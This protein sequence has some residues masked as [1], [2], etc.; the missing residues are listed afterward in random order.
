MKNKKMIVDTK[1][2]LL[3]YMEIVESLV[4]NAMEMGDYKAYATTLFSMALFYNYCV[5]DSRFDLEHDIDDIL[6]V[7]ILADDEKFIEEYTKAIRGDGMVRLDFANAVKDAEK[8]IELKMNSV[9]S[10]IDSIKNGVEEIG[11]TF[12]G[13]LN[14][15]MLNKFNDFAK[16]TK[17]DTKSGKANLKEVVK[18]TYE[19]SGRI[20]DIANGK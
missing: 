12:N 20:K 15:E 11:E 10:I 1:L 18:E 5:K 14:D 13:L 19:K 4:N 7:E 2:N 3:S 17:L 6:E 9:S 8:T 16:L